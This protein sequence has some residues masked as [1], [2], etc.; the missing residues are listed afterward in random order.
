MQSE[1][2]PEALYFITPLAYFVQVSLSHLQDG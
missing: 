1:G 2:L